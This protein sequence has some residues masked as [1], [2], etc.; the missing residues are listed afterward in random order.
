MK[1][2]GFNDAIAGTSELDIAGGK[3]DV[4]GCYCSGHRVYQF[5]NIGDSPQ[6]RAF[7]EGGTP[8]S[9]RLNEG[10]CLWGG[11]P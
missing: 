2:Q 6:G 7:P 3:C 1:Q 5:A 4:A 11:S 9:K 8:V 10:P